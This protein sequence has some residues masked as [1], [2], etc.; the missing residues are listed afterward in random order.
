[1]RKLILLFTFFAGAPLLFLS[2]LLY[3]LFLAHQ[4]NPEQARFSNNNQT[5]A[6]AYAALPSNQNSFE[7]DIVQEEAR[8]ETIRQFLAKYNSPLEPHAEFIV[9][10]A[11][12]YGIDH[13]LIPAIAMQE[14]NLCKKSRP[15]A[16]NCW[17]YG[18]YGK[19]YMHFD[20]YEQAIETVTKSLA[21][22]YKSKGLH[23]PEE[24]MTRYTPSSNGS[25]AR[26]VTYFMEQ[27][28]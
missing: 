9:Q 16:Y 22:T 18:I 28:Q 11:D 10:I 4:N 19:N 23:T 24:I 1:M 6:I 14:S 21:T 3:F 25:W 26:G 12:Q 27:L 7:D 13:R 8:V 5:R 15:E 2:C 20:N 17:G